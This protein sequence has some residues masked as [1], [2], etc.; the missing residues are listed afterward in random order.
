MQAATGPAGASGATGPSGP[1]GPAGES[2][3]K[4]IALLGLDQVK[5]RAGK[6]VKVRLGATSP[7]DATLDVLKGSKVAASVK[8]SLSAAGRDTITWNGRGLARAARK[9]KP[10]KPGK[11]TLR[12]TVLGSDGQ[13][14]TDTAQLKL[15]K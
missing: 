15:T 1:Q 4:L 12:L 3:I 13:K 10:L 7:G 11:Y 2:A 5:A 6:R 8:K 9:P 14:A